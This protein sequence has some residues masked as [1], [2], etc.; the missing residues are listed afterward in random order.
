[1]QELGCM[2]SELTLWATVVQDVAK[3][4]SIGVW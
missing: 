4:E 2:C 3:R 1:M